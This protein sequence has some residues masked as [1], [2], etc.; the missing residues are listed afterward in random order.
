M[1]E[2]WVDEFVAD[3]SPAL[4][5]YRMAKPI[6][7]NPGLYSPRLVKGARTKFQNARDEIAWLLDQWEM[8]DGV[9]EN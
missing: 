8:D 1:E 4:F 9:S 6:V 5:R 3:L 2:E 7:D